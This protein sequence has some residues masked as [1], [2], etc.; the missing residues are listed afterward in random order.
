MMLVI[1]I[2]VPRAELSKVIL[3]LLYSWKVLLMKSIYVE[4]TRG[5][6]N[7]VVDVCEMLKAG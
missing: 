7:C 3:C 1:V 4:N 2:F 5:D 6:G